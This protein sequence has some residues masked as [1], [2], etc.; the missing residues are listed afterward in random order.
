[1]Q[2]LSEK[3]MVPS[4][5][6]GNSEFGQTIQKQHCSKNTNLGRRGTIFAQHQSRRPFDDDGRHNHDTVRHTPQEVCHEA[7]ATESRTTGEAPSRPPR[8]GMTRATLTR[9]SSAVDGTTG[10]LAHRIHLTGG[11]RRRAMTRQTQLILSSVHMSSVMQNQKKR[12]VDFIA[13][14]L[15]FR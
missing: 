4:F 14:H 1:M 9:S 8:P 6:G 15:A 10:G 5:L 2:R 7:P 12:R 3:K 13:A 11:H